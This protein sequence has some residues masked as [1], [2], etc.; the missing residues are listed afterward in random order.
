MPIATDSL[1]DLKKVAPEADALSL[2]LHLRAASGD[3]TSTLDKA[4]V[5][6]DGSVSGVVSH[7]LDEV[8]NHPWRFASEM[9]G[10]GALSLAL[11]GPA[12]VKLPATAVAAVGTG[13]FGLHS[14]E[15]GHKTYQALAGMNEGNYDRT[16]E[17]VAAQ[18]G[19]V[20]FDGLL[21]G[22]TAHLGS[23]INLPEKFPDKVL[24]ESLNGSLNK[25]GEGLGLGEKLAP[26]GPDIGIKP[27]DLSHDNIMAMT[28]HQ[29]DGITLHR[30]TG[31]RG[32]RIQ[33]VEFLKPGQTVEFK[34]PD[35]SS[36]RVSA[37][38]K[39]LAGFATG[40]ARL[41]DIGGPINRVHVSEFAGGFKQI[42]LND[43][44]MPNLEINAQ[45]HSVKAA[46]VSGDHVHLIDNVP[47]GFMKF[48]HKDGLKSWIEYSGRLV[49]QLPNGHMSEKTLS[50]TAGLANIKLTERVD[51]SKVFQFTDPQLRV[52]S[53]KVELPPT[54][55]I[56]TFEELPLWSNKPVERNRPQDQVVTGG[57][58]EALSYEPG[59]GGMLK[60]R[61]SEKRSFAPWDTRLRPVPMQR[62]FDQ[63]IAGVD[64]RVMRGDDLST[65][66]S[67]GLAQQGH[68]WVVTRYLQG[69]N[70]QDKIFPDD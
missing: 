47:G 15:A 11:K 63:H 27:R 52:I 25:L 31:S 30:G 65:P 60:P 12:W 61:Q 29:A 2:N 28:I 43:A 18:M 49:F 58:G 36:T 14:L 45:H 7:G 23:K 67:M 42:R 56:H 48:D 10:A 41:V 33:L 24:T 26:A 20:L 35:L 21:M 8:A 57:G 54:P 5:L 32:E 55:Q 3:G 64:P 1:V 68:G 53:Q 66:A 34:H 62:V 59:P 16:R 22:A 19:S 9:A 40:E 69:L 44:I 70:R 51:G 38:G 6:L 37:D 46:L 39:V 17:L 4:R 50:G 13:T